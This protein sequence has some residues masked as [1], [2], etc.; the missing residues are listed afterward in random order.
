MAFKR[1]LRTFHNLSAPGPPIT[2]ERLM[3][4]EETCYGICFQ[5]DKVSHLGKKLFLPGLLDGMLYKL[6]MQ[7]PQKSDCWTFQKTEWPSSSPASEKKLSD[8]LLQK[9]PID[10]VYQSKA[11]QIFKFP[12]SLKSLS[13]IMGLSAEDGCPNITKE[14]WVTIQAAHYFCQS[15]NFGHCLQCTSCLLR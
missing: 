10:E 7:D 4:T 12:A 11:K 9:K 8:I 5:C 1:F 15:W 6:N 3:G 14:L 2:S 13:D